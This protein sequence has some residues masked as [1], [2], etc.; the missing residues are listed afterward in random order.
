MAIFHYFVL[1]EKMMITFILTTASN[2]VFTTH[3]R[4]G[5]LFFEIS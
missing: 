4:I 1:Y 3:N 5:H 2:A